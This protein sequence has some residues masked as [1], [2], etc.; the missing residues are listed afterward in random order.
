MTTQPTDEDVALVRDLMARSEM[1]AIEYHEL[2][3]KWTGSRDEA[4]DEQDVDIQLEIQ[5]RCGDADFGFRIVGSVTAPIGEA[6]A[7][8]AITYDY[9]GEPPLQRTL[10]AFGNEVAVMAVFP[11]FRESVHSITSK[12][13]G[14]PILLPVLPR[15]VIGLDLDEAK[16]IPANSR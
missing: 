12:V 6:S 8:V 13:F 7:A 11:Y 5:H 15:G 14:Q 2:S 9:E 10:F 3:A 16:D 4:D 1:R